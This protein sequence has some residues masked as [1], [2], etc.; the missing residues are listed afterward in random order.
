MD[1]YQQGKLRVAILVI[2]IFLI[3]SISLAAGLLAWVVMFRG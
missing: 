2:I 1:E 3:L